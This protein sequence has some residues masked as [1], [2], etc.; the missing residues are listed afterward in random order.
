M[1][2]MEYLVFKEFLILQNYSNENLLIFSQLYFFSIDEPLKNLDNKNLDFF[3]I[4]SFIVNL[5]SER[6]IKDINQN[7]NNRDKLLI[8]LLNYFKGL[9]LKDKN[10]LSYYSFKNLLTFSYCLSVFCDTRIRISD[11]FYRAYVLE[12]L[13]E[14]LIEKKAIQQVIFAQFSSCFLI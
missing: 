1:I 14:S 11:I 9:Y 12:S 3:F 5:N 4:D 6:L 13:K 10:L 7:I 8:I 2:F